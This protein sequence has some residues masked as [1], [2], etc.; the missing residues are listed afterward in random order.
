MTVDTL[1]G[2]DLNKQAA[3]TEGA[4]AVGG[5]MK[6]VGV[7]A[8]L[9]S[10]GGAVYKVVQS[11]AEMRD[12][13]VQV[14][15]GIERAHEQLIAGDYAAAWGSYAGAQAIASAD[16]LI[17]RMLGG[18]SEEQQTIVTDRQ[19][20]AM[21]W[22]RSAQT[23]P[24]QGFAAVVKPLQQVLA[25]GANS[26]AGERSADLH[27]HLG[28]AYFLQ[29]RDG[30]SGLNPDAEYREAVAIDAKNPYANAFWG[31]WILWNHGSLAE[32]Q[33]KFVAALASKR[34]RGEV[35]YFQLAALRNVGSHDADVAFMTAVNA[36]RLAGDPI[37]GETV[38]HIADVYSEAFHDPSVMV[39]LDAGLS[40]GSQADLLQLVAKTG[41][42]TDTQLFVLQEGRAASLQRAGRL[43][44]SFAAW[45]ELQAELK[46][47]PSSSYFEAAN[48]SVRQ[49][50]ARMQLRVSP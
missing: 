13:R 42:A 34:E 27:A 37:D 12:R 49:L 2:D 5:M 43:E 28:W 33:K 20:L 21:Q 14:E 24:G 30:V 23:Q 38:N 48:T 11:T 26:T 10:F 45:K 9:I 41:G 18:L 1:Q 47:A 36:M 39:K 7:L 46:S 17:A 22:I 29:Q 3:A 40:P 44:D 50:Q 31:H 32:A 15:Q 6:W 25:D 8:A 35:R 4:G 19:E 16:G